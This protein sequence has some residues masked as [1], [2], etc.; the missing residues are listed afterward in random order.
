MKR[1]DGK[2]ILVAGGGN[3]G[4]ECARR[5]AA[6]GAQVVIGDIKIATAQTGVRAIRDTGSEAE[7]LLLD[8]G[9]ETSIRD[10][11]AFTVDR[12][13]GLDGLHPNF[14]CVIEG[15]AGTSVL[16]LGL[17]YYDQVFRV[18]ARGFML[19]TR[20]ALPHIIARGG[21]AITYTS[22]GAA[23]QGVATRFAYSM[24]K[25][26]GQ[27]LMRHV[28]TRFGADGVRAN[29]LAPGVI[30]RPGQPEEIKDIARR[31]AKIPRLGQAPD[32]A[33]VAALLMSDEGSYITGQIINIDGGITMRA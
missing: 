21:G 28:A 11:V 25:A 6:E 29:S 22:A 18:N 5:Y 12:F 24:S 20:Y 4:N 10:A 8:G 16:D 32:I 2:V 30:E 13:G 7:A 14:A 27:A 1:L 3:I 23:N 19:C 15:T 31:L 17:D 33:A 26:A 9:D